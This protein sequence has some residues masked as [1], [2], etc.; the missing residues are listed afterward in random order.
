MTTEVR[1][2]G[3]DGDTLEIDVSAGGE[4][5]ARY[6]VSVRDRGEGA[7]VEGE[8]VSSRRFGLRR[9]PQGLVADRYYADAL[10]AQ[11]YTVDDRTAS[12]SMRDP[13]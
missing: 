2:R 3:P 12:F 10:A 11:E 8:L 4:P 6:A 9:L 5:W 1:S 13:D 7:V